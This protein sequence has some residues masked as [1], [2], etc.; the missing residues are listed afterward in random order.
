[1]PKVFLESSVQSCQGFEVNVAKRPIDRLT[2][3]LAAYIFVDFKAR[4]VPCP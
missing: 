2:G 4:D 3:R 1:M